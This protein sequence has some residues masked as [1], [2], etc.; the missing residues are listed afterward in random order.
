MCSGARDHACWNG[1][2][3]DGLD[4]AK[5]LAAALLGVVESLPEFDAKFRAKV[6]AAASAK[7]SIRDAALTRLDGEITRA[8]RELSNLA[9]VAAEGSFSPTLRKK[10][11]T[12][13]IVG[14]LS[15]KIANTL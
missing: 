8:E 3:F 13:F 5:R 14:V 7:R 4:A 9:D 15:W 6:E 2:T 11:I 12:R 1:A 10:P